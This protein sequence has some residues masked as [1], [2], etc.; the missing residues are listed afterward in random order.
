MSFHI[1]SGH[2]QGRHPEVCEW[3]GW[4]SIP[5]KGAGAIGRGWVPIGQT[6][7]P[8]KWNGAHLHILRA[9]DPFLQCKLELVHKVE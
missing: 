8:C 1:G 6:S 9:S 5:G 7:Q 3:H 4:T 2:G